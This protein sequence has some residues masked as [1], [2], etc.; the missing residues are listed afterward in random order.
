MTL[1]N[2]AGVICGRQLTPAAAAEAQAF[3]G[4]R[5]DAPLE[6]VDLAGAAVA[7]EQPEAFVRLL[8]RLLE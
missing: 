7:E 6:T 8:R 5:P 3:A 2:V 1:S 4:F